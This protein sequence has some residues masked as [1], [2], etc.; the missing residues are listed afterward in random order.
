MSHKGIQFAVAADISGEAT[1]HRG[2]KAGCALADGLQEKDA[3]R[4]D[5]ALD[6]VLASKTA[7]DE[8]VDQALRRL[9][10]E[11]SSRLCQN[12]HACSEIDRV[13]QSGDGCA[14]FVIDATDDRSSGV[15]AD[16][17]LRPYTVDGFDLRGLAHEP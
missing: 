7:L 4:L 17:E 3:L 11:H 13:P 9:S 2:V 16:P 10:Q 14:F 12:L 5:F 6:R 1:T 15:D 8:A